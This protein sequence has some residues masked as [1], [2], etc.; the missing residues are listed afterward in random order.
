MK[1]PL[2]PL[3]NRRSWLTQTGAGFG[4][5]ALLDLLAADAG[6]GVAGNGPA[7]SVIQLFMYGG[8][9]Q[10]DTFDP[11]PELQARNGE[12][13]PSSERIRPFF[14]A[15]GPLL[16]SPFSFAQH[17]QS[18]AWVSELFPELAKVVDDVAFIKSMHADSN[19][20]APALFEMNTG[21]IRPGSPCLGTWV[22]YGLGTSNQNLPGFVVMCDDEGGPIGGAANWSAGYLPGSNAGMVMR[23]HGEPIL[24][25]SRHAPQSPERVQADRTLLEAINHDHLA[26]HA[27]EPELETRIKSY[28]LA[29][30]MQSEAP[31]AVDI[32]RESAETRSLYGLDNPVT[33]SFGRRLL[34]A[35]RLAE[36]G[37]RFI[38]VYSGSGGNFDNRNWDAHND[39]IK[40]HRR[41]AAATDKPVAALMV[42]LKRRGLLDQTLVLW[43]GEFGRLPISQAK[44]GRDHNPHGFTV[45]MAGGGIKGGVS[46][47]ATDDFG[48]RATVD[49]YHINDW[50]ATILHLSL[51]H[52]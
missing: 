5:L 34:M 28:E 40:N 17:G 16:A 44:I 33:A 4:A 2:N 30:R 39:L 46:V 19:N 29:F 51:I 47:G 41:H 24:N 35:R 36:R 42:D 6:A 11:K 23:S 27:G 8:P 12:A 52:I 31:E 48:Y 3:M 10:V 15:P 21:Q 50:H 49:P 1:S 18:G 20:H 25:L 7:K 26:N 14:G 43:G 22:Q 32:S 38:Q 9:S 37:V 45:W 13:F